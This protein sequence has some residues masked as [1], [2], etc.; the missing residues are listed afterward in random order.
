MWWKSGPL[1]ILSSTGSQRMKLS[2]TMV[3][4]QNGLFVLRSLR[5][6]KLSPLHLIRRNS[7]TLELQI[8]STLVQDFHETKNYTS[9]SQNSTTEKRQGKDVRL[10]TWNGNEK[11]RLRYSCLLLIQVKPRKS[12][13]MPPRMPGKGQSLYDRTIVPVAHH[14][15]WNIMRVQS[16]SILLTWVVTP[17]SMEQTRT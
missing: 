9:E 8:H 15:V 4:W 7:L 1:S 14:K 13:K 6:S 5:I 2:I 10:W 12:Y 17:G 16:S 3:T 11:E